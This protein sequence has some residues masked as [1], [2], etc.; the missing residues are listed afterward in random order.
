M[1]DFLST[2]LS[3]F[4]WLAVVIVAMIPGLEGRVAIPFALSLNNPILTPYNSF[5]FSFLGSILPFFL[6]FFTAK[7]IGRKTTGFLHDKTTRF[8]DGRYRTKL[9]KVNTANSSLRKC[10]LLFGFVAIPLPLTGVWSGSLIAGL[11][12]L[13]IFESF[14]SIALGS[15]VSC[16]II[17]LICMVFSNSV[18]Y[19][20]IASLIILLIYIVIEIIVSRRRKRRG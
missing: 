4:L 12:S 11:S 13:S 14:T 3:E 2:N 15:M 7:L 5:L 1:L 16:S 18:I 8:I 9:L 10:F 6:V 20:L 17:L 19:F